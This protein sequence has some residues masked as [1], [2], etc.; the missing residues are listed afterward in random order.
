MSVGAQSR[1]A[2]LV[3]A[4]RS[5]VTAGLGGTTFEI[6]VA[7]E[8]IATVECTNP[9][10]LP[11][12]RT[13]PSTYRAPAARSRRHGTAASDSTSKGA[14]PNPLPAT[15]TCP[16]NQWTPTITDVTFGDAT[17]TLLEDGAVS[18]TITVP[19]A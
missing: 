3:A 12:A 14:D 10:T 18:D 6:T 17:I 8:G 9:G 13:Q 19:V 4:R 15:P 1:P 2:R 7:A 11:R 16:N 5:T